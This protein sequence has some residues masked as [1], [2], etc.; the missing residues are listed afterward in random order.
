[1]ILVAS[2]MAAVLLA[3]QVLF[4]VFG[5]RALSVVTPQNRTLSP[6]LLF[7]N[8]IPLFQF[9]WAFRSVAAVAG[10][11]RREVAAQAIDDGRSSCGRDS[12]IVGQAFLLLTIVL[13]AAIPLIADAIYKAQHVYS[14]YVSQK[15][16]TSLGYLLYGLGLASFVTHIVLLVVHFVAVSR[17]T[18][19]VRMAQR[20]DKHAVAARLAAKRTASARTEKAGATTGHP[21]GNSRR[22]TGV[23]PSCNGRLLGAFALVGAILASIGFLLYRGEWLANVV[24]LANLAGAT[25]ALSTCLVRRTGQAD[26]RRTGAVCFAISIVANLVLLL[27]GLSQSAAVAWLFGAGLLVQIAGSTLFENGSGKQSTLAA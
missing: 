6:G 1:M 7:L 14:G 8:L 20:G 15:E 22:D 2:M 3:L 24:N 12:G 26:P 23:V 27:V 5:Y 21:A 18:K 11:L 4:L 16:L 17:W 25:L 13:A 9:G 19:L 10:S